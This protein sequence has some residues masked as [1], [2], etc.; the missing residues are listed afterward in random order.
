MVEFSLYQP[1]KPDY[2][3]PWHIKIIY[4]P[5]VTLS[6]VLTTLLLKKRQNHRQALSLLAC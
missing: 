3:D 6:S 1:K 5:T 4:K 2:I